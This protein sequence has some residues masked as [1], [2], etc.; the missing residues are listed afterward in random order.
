[1]RTNPQAHRY[2]VVALLPR[3]IPKGIESKERCALPSILDDRSMNTRP[4]LR[5]IDDEA[6]PM[7]TDPRGE[8]QAIIL[9]SD[10]G[11]S[12]L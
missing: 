9:A 4:L 6:L 5:L 10:T 2:T 7:N 3:S 1:V 11:P 12:W 8:E